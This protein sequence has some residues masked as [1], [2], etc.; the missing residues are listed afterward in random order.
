MLKLMS[1]AGVNCILALILSS[2]FLTHV[3]GAQKLTEDHVASFI[4]EMND[5]SNG[6]RPGMDKYN[7]MSYF[8]KHVDDKG[9]FVDT[10]K[11]DFP[12]LQVAQ[13]ER[14]LKMTKLDY[15]SHVMQEVD[16][17]GE[18]KSSIN[19]ENI[20][21]ADS[22]QEAR[23]VTTN[24]GNGMIPVQDNAGGATMVPVVGTSFC[25]QTLIMREG[26]ILVHKTNCST[27]LNMDDGSSQ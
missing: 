26:E 21:I 10:V 20:Q 25:E 5:I 18:H 4:H 22:G 27:A 1:L 3:K 14:T 19:I 15:I 24:R 12:D 7:I 2:S 11:Y 17:S 8:M 9:E 23:V 16:P 13:E 6:A